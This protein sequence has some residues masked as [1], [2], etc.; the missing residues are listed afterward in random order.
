MTTFNSSDFE[1]ARKQYEAE[2]KDLWG[3]TK[4]FK[5]HEKKTSSY[6]KD[7]WQEVNDGLMAIFSKFAECRKNGHSASSDKAQALAGELKAYITENYYTCTNEIL[8]G[9][10]QMYVADERFKNNIDKLGKGTAEFVR[11]TIEIYCKGQNL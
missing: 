1:T 3:S 11:D 6:S 4:A 9:L 10:S 2:A 5:E 8:K 7:K